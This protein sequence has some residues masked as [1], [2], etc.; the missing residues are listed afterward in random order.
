MDQKEKSYKWHNGKW[1]LIFDSWNDR[2]YYLQC[3]IEGDMIVINYLN[4]TIY[5]PKNQILI[6]L[7]FEIIYNRTSYP[8]HNWNI[9]IKDYKYS[10]AITIGKFVWYNA[11]L[12]YFLPYE[13]CFDHSYY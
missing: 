3:F 1:L 9:E 2:K 13:I 7:S 5:V 11:I 8:N 10:W 12:S 4:F 6:E